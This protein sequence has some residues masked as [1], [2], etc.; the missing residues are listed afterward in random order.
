MWVWVEQALECDF[1]LSL[2]ECAF[3]LLVLSCRLCAYIVSVNKNSCLW[4]WICEEGDEGKNAENNKQCELKLLRTQT[5]NIGIHTFMVGYDD[6]KLRSNLEQLCCA[7]LSSLAQHST[8]SHTYGKKTDRRQSMHS[9]RAWY[10][11]LCTYRI[12]MHGFWQHSLLRVQVIVNAGWRFSLE[13]TSE[14]RR[15]TFAERL[16]TLTTHL[17]NIE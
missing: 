4:F 17:I 3:A 15:I 1:V 6:S 11:H 2:C 14:T 7:F 5:I 12:H 13:M 10:I 16:I 9:E 8:H